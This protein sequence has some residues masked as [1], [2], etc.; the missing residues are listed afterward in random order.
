MTSNPVSGRIMQKLGMSCEGTHRQ[1]ALRFGSYED[2][3]MCAILHSEY[4]AKSM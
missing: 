3:A 4:E 1:A 2:V